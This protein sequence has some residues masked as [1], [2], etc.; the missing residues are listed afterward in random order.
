MRMAT[1][2]TTLRCDYCKTVVI[3]R[4]DASGIHFLDEVFNDLN[5]PVCNVPLSNAT[6][7]GVALCACRHCDGTFISMGVFESLLDTL[8]AQVTDPEIP[9]PPDPADLKRRMNCPKCRAPLDMHFY[10]G[11]GSSVIGAC[12]NCSAN[13]LDGGVLMRIARAPHAEVPENDY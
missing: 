5:C 4:T 12:E 7:A 3:A 1:G 9:S 8:R 13:W 2:D 11:G 6:V 10:L